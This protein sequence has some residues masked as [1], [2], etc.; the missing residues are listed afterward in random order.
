[1]KRTYRQGSCLVL[2]WGPPWNWLPSFEKSRHCPGAWSLTWLWWGL[3]YVPVSYSTLMLHGGY[4]RCQD[5]HHWRK[6]DQLVQEQQ[7]NEVVQTC[8]YCIE[9][10]CP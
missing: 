8:V 9:D 1:M 5:C 7:G 4:P 3:C 10:R 2:S 6:P